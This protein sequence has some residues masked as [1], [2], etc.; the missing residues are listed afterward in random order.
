MAYGYNYGGYPAG[1]YYAPPM[2]DQLA[3]LRNNQYNPGMMQ[4]PGIQMQ[5]NMGNQ[6]PAMQPV[7]N[8]QMSMAPGNGILWVSGEKEA[9]EYPLAVNSAVA[10]W[11]SNNPVIYLKQSD[12]SGKPSMKIYDL[13]ERD[14]SAQTPVKQTQAQA[15]DYVTRREFEALQARFDA[16]MMASATGGRETVKTAKKTTAKTEDEE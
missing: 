6:V 13:V 16:L 12:A 4:Q 11:D 3:Q 9:N 2:P 5:N 10:L 1:G 14:T 15:V 8:Q 7:N